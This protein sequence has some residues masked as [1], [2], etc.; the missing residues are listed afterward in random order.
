MSQPCSLSAVAPAVID[1]PNTKES[2]MDPKDFLELLSKTERL[3]ME[4]RCP[5]FYFV[6]LP[7]QKARKEFLRRTGITSRA[8]IKVIKRIQVESSSSI[9]EEELDG[10]WGYHITTVRIKQG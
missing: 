8:L 9:F 3:Y 1:T 4:F 6:P 7:G 2:T 5:A 10:V